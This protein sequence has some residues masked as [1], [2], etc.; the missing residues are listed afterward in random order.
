MLKLSVSESR[1]SRRCS[2][3]CV[4]LS[5]PARQLQP[6]R[7]MCSWAGG[8]VRLTSVDFSEASRQ[9]GT[10]LR[11]SDSV[12]GDAARER[13]KI[14]DL[15]SICRYSAAEER[16]S[17]QKVSSSDDSGTIEPSQHCLLFTHFTIINAGNA[18]MWVARKDSDLF[19]WSLCVF[20]TWHTPLQTNKWRHTYYL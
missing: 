4:V 10:C 9:S 13:M 19:I 1:A 7:G 12:L 3:A 8:W 2:C 20:I 17:L 6:A 15:V 16:K 14:L 11:H 5:L 18:I